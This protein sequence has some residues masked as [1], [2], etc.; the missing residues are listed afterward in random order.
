[1]K[2]LRDLEDFS[3]KWLVAMVDSMPP[4]ILKGWIITLSTEQ[5]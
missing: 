5:A 4:I 2:D 1:M 3:P